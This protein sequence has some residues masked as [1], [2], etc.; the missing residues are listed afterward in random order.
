[1]A[2]VTLT[3]LKDHLYIDHND[4]DGILTVYLNTAHS[5]LYESLGLS[6]SDISG[7]ANVEDLA[8]AVITLRASHWFNYRL[9]VSDKSMSEVPYTITALMNLILYHYENDDS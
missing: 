2:L 7:V 4:D 1:M 6:E 3:E 5:Y 8:K 9:P